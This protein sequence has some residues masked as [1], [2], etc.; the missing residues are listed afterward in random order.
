MQGQGQRRA[1]ERCIAVVRV[2]IEGAAVPSRLRDLS[3]SGVGLLSDLP[4]PVGARLKI[5]LPLVF[6][7]GSV[8]IG[9]QAEV[10]H[11]VYVTSLQAFRVGARLVD[12]DPTA[13]RLIERYLGERAL[14]LGKRASP[15]AGRS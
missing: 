1:A 14:Q 12:V 11:C 5:K 4:H 2:D 8:I 3:L 13:T 6:N 7:A 15:V 10:R 9:I